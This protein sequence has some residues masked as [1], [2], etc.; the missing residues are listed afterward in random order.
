MSE[1]S[2]VL[3]S[4]AH[5]MH[6]KEPLKALPQTV[7]K[8]DQVL[9][10]IALVALG[11]LTFGIVPVYYYRK[12]KQKLQQFN[13]YLSAQKVSLPVQAL[14]HSQEKPLQ[15]QIKILPAQEPQQNQEASLQNQTAKSSEQSVEINSSPNPIA[16]SSISKLLDSVQSKEEF[17]ADEPPQNPIYNIEIDSAKLPAKASE[18]KYQNKTNDLKNLISA[19][20]L[21]PK[22]LPIELQGEFQGLLTPLLSPSFTRQDLDAVHGKAATFLVPGAKNDPNFKDRIIKGREQIYQRLQE[23]SNQW[24]GKRVSILCNGSKIDAYILGKKDTISNGRW[25][26]FSNGHGGLAEEAALWEWEH[27]QKIQS[28][29]IIYNYPG[30]GC[31]EGPRARNRMVASYEAIMCFLEDREKGIGAKEI[32]GWGTSMGGG[33]QGHAR[34]RHEYKKD[35]RYAFVDNQT[36]R[37]VADA[38]GSMKSEHFGKLVKPLGW[39]LSSKSSEKLNHPQIVVQRATKLH[40]EAKEDILHDGLFTPEGSLAGHLLAK[41]SHWPRKKIVGITAHHCGKFS[42]EELKEIHQAVAKALEPGFTAF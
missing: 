5:L 31:S 2:K 25:T 28:N 9:S 22:S 3:L 35:V 40:P 38:V 15:N 42:D 29:M 21:N 23:N 16:T 37:T 12:A 11:I 19:S 27:A 24:V 7:S 30:V 14:Q 33:V 41:N 39:Q 34:K 6:A 20:G 32:I 36:Y 26:L 10:G 4:T 8:V 18:K 1:L 13:D 17:L